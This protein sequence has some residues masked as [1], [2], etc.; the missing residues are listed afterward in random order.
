MKCSWNRRDLLGA[1][2]SAYGASWLG[3]ETLAYGV[4]SKLELGVI[5]AGVRS[6]YLLAGLPSRVTV[7]ALCDPSLAQI[8]SVRNPKAAFAEFANHYM[9]LGVHSAKVYQ[10]YRRMLEEEKLDAVI[11]AA[12]DHHHA[13]AAILAMQKGCDC[14]V[15]KP[16]ALTIAEGRAIVEAAKKHKRIVQV[17]SQQRSMPANRRICEAIRDGVFG[18]VHRVEERNLPGPMPID[19]SAFPE[20][21]VPTDFDWDLFCGPSVL[22]AYN[23]HLWRKDVFKRGYLLWR[24]WD[25]FDDFSGHL[26]TNWGAHSIDMVQYALGMDHSGPTKVELVDVTESEAIQ[27]LDDL[28]HDKTPPLGALRDRRVD[29]ARFTPLKMTYE[30]GVELHFK[31]GVR[32]TTFHCEAGTV[33]VGRNRY[34]TEPLDLFPPYTKA[35]DADWDGDGHVAGPHLADWLHAI[36]VRGTVRASPEAAHRTA[37]ICHLAKIARQTGIDLTWDPKKERFGRDEVNQHL[38]RSRRPGWSW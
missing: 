34:W 28:W 15:E 29:R 35:D 33:W 26:M 22:H 20:Q 16:L 23:E 10:D 14:Y 30:N 5:G 27:Q 25:L 36:E 7:R 37:T 2:S 17:G 32:R 6:K 21:P 18:R 31:P 9:E 24:G 3:A 19:T 8:E 12:P 11:V 1:L 13:L 4:N 38:T